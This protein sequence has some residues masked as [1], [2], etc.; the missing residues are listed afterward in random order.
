MAWPV[1][2]IAFLLLFTTTAWAQTGTPAI[3]VGP[4]APVPPEWLGREMA[5]V[6]ACQAATAPLDPS[7]HTMV[8]DVD[9]SQGADTTASIVTSSGNPAFDRKAVQ[10]LQ[11]LPATFTNKIVGDLSMFVPVYANNGAVV[12]Q[13]DPS[14]AIVPTQ[15]PIANAINPNATQPIDLPTLHL[16]L[17]TK[18]AVALFCGLTVIVCSCIPSFSCQTAIVYVPAG[19]FLSS[20]FPSSIETAK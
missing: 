1:R 15:K 6:P 7:P 2:T 14:K 13:T 11:N 17:N 16:P 9:M 12:P 3:T 5:S 19:R 8:V 4:N 18:S 10:C 20:T